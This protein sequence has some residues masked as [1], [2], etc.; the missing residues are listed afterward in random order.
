MDASTLRWLVT[1][2]FGAHGI[3]M[4]GAA[5]YLPFS[6]RSAKDDFIGASWLLGNTGSAVVLGVVVWAIAGAGFLAAAFGFWQGAEWWRIAAWVGSVFT[7]LAIA[8]WAG[9]VPFGVYVG[10]ALALGTIGYL[11]L[12]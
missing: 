6:I 10:G 3:G 4:L 5:G 11:L 12:A 1:G 8:L 2:A 7:L 9:S